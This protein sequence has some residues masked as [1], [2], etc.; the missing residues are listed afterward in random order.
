MSDATDEP[1]RPLV[2]RA[3]PDD[4]PAIADAHVRG[5]QVAYRGLVPDAT[6]DGFSTERRT[7][8]WH[9]RLVDERPQAQLARIWVV[10]DPDGE[11]V[12]F[13]ATGPANDEAAPPPPGAGEVFA[14]YLRPE[15]WGRGY[16]PALLAHAVTDLE[17]RGYTPVVIWVF[18][19]NRRA[20]HVYEAA[21]FRADGARHRL[22]FDTVQLDEI[23]YR[24]DITA[25]PGRAGTGA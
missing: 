13:A 4:A 21:G 18:D 25:T 20:R 2:R 16:G 7:A 12:G 24:R 22:T 15:A 9:D 10:E 11:V 6:L 19:E 17:M 1:G 23:R 14:I 5:W 8:F 3:D